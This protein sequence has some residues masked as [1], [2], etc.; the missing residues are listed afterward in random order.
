[1]LEAIR[2]VMGEYAGQ[3]PI[4]TFLRKTNNGIPNDIAQLNKLRFV[5]SSEVPEGRSLDESKV[6]YMT[7][8]GTMQG[9]FLFKELFEFQPSYKLLIDTNRMPRVPGNEKAVWNRIRVIPLN[10][11]I[12]EAEKDKNLLAK[13]QA[14]AAGILNWAVQGCLDWQKNGL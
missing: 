5:T 1:F 13:L 6:K 10:A 3:V 14:E 7:G 8:M 4:E 9:R 12:T 11:T 2:Y